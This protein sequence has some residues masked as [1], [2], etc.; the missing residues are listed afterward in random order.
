MYQIGLIE[1]LA[2]ERPEIIRDDL[3][4]QIKK[5]FAYICGPTVYDD[6][7]LGHARVYVIFDMMTRVSNDM[8]AIMNIT[9]IDDKIIN[10]AQQEK[11]TF[12]EIALIYERSFFNSMKKLNVLKPKFL[13]RVTD[14]IPEI[15]KYINKIISNGYAYMKGGSVYFD[16]KAYELKY[17]IG[18]LTPKGQT[19]ADFVMW[20]SAKTGEPCWNSP[21]G[22]GRPGWHIECSTLATTISP[23][24]DLH[25]GGIDLKF[26]HHQNEVYQCNAHRNDQKWCKKFLHIG[27]LHINGLKM[28]KSLKNFIKIDEIF[29][30]FGKSHSSIEIANSLRLLF[31]KSDWKKNMNF[32]MD[33]L[34]ESF[35]LW[36]SFNSFVRSETTIILSSK[37]LNSVNKGIMNNES[38]I[39]KYL[40]NYDFHLVI[41]AIS[42]IV[43]NTHESQRTNELKKFVKN[44]LETLGFVF[45]GNNDIL[46]ILLKFRKQMRDVAK[47]SEK[48]TRKDL[49]KIS[50]SL[51]DDLKSIGIR[52]EDNI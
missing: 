11:K 14:Y 46:P 44:T 33:S 32:S 7:H 36:F 13:L 41:G 34:Q 3:S 40:S 23:I 12:K 19:M 30:N 15:I 20:K 43:F 4:S 18:N 35:K 10:K 48:N 9:D 39:E 6:S 26:P 45:E 50:D 8:V 22:N 25:I 28:G 49:F 52:I 42:K 51:R 37:E 16:S 38:I 17:G 47:K 2:M 5:K 21:W 1:I 27:H 24:I 31:A 29:H